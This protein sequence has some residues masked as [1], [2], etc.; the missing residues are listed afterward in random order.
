VRL[1]RRPRRR[2]V[3]AL[4]AAAGTVLSLA[5]ALP[6][7]AAPSS[8][9]WQAKTPPLSTPWTSQVGPDNA[10][11][12][13]PRPQLT[14][15]RWKNLN[16]VWQFEA[17]DTGDKAPIGQTL[18]ERILVPYPVESALSGIMRHEDDMFYRRTFTVPANWRTQQQHVLLHFG[19]VDFD[20]TVY[21]N[22]TKVAHH[23]GG[24]DAFTAD[25]TSA[26]TR[27]GKQEI[28][29]HVTDP[30]DAG[31]QPVGKQRNNPGG[32]FYTPSSG[33]WQTVWAEPVASAHVDSLVTTPKLTDDTVRVTPKTTGTISGDTLVASVY[34]GNKRVGSASGAPGAQLRVAVP[35][36]KLWSPNSPYLY[37]L[38][39]AIRHKQETL[40]TV[41]SYFGMRSVGIKKD[42]D[43]KPR[44]VLNGKPIF[45]MATLDQGFWPDGIYTAPTDSALKFDLQQHK[46]L[47]FNAVRKHI[48]VEPDRWYYWADKLG[49]MVFQDMP[50]M[51]TDRRPDAAAQA[52]YKRE[53]QRMI[54]QHKSDTA[55]IAWVPFNEGWGE[56]DPAT[57][58][59]LV[60]KLDP[61][62]LVDAESG[63]NCCASLPDTGEGDVWD[64]HTYV[65]PGA[66]GPQSR[67][68]VI[69]GEYGGLGLEEPGHLWPGPT[70]AYEMEPDSATLTARYVQLQQRLKQVQN[71]CGV[72]AGIYTQI[73]DVENEINGLYTY[74][75]KVLK[76]DAAK[77]KAA[78]DAVVN[79]A[80]AAFSGSGSVTYPVGQSAPVAAYPLDEGSGATAHDSAGGHDLALTGSPAWV[81]GHSGTAL[82]L[83]G[84]SQS[85]ET[86]GTVVDTQG[87]FS[88]SAWVKLD[89][90]GH[91]ATA[92]SEDGPSASS[93]FLQYSAA[94]GRFAFSTV[95]GRALADTAPQ[96]GQWYHLV[97]VHDGNAGTYTLYVDGKAQGSVLHQCL[98]DP[99]TGPL[100]V[101]RGFYGGSPTDFWPGTVDDVRVWNR[102]LSAADVGGLS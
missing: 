18:P 6:S 60:K 5:A 84:S 54:A 51:T 36:A 76:M 1:S 89:S 34:Q 68:I 87:N 25:A 80:Q 58:A 40:D 53:L 29:V 94:D 101:G 47:G 69:D 93:F 61:S 9:A 2:A 46:A 91:F 99:A 41:G 96:V 98:G 77:V 45:A 13:Y 100:A 63:V 11:P 86:S 48:K 95:E 21:V 27:E 42:A 22:G 81:A 52:E 59:A 67:R 88:V 17:A 55:I 28:V 72:S 14:R 82:Q 15:S 3:A 12:Q 74:D 20:A 23:R 83:D 26:L 79:N 65:G 92:V 66:P 85:G 44:L 30:T 62:R 10:L 38:K 71:Q 37:T 39:V 56:F 90:T 4:A 24:Y 8:P 73:T 78:N 35:H 70:Q 7:E 75:R 43:G 31:G 33:I 19:A 16:G 57:I 97:G 32:I 50:A 49:L 102:A 64:D